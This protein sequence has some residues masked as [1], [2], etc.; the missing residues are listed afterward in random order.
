MAACPCAFV[1]A[2]F[3][4]TRLYDW[5]SEPSEPW[6]FGITELF[7]SLLRRKGAR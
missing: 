1:S 5:S 7:E 6:N 2:T 4:T 3:A